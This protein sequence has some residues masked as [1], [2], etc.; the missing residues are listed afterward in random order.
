MIAKLEVSGQHTKITPDLSKYITKKIGKLDRYIP[1]KARES[2]HAEVKL[3]ESKAKNKKQC[4]CEVVLFLPHEVITV[5]EATLNM[6]AAIDIV[7]TRLKN[8]IKSYKEKHMPAKFH[9]RFIKK[10]QSR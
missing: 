5:K 6:F 1:R 7:E 3:V 2:A 4:S 10:F 8:Q 9:R